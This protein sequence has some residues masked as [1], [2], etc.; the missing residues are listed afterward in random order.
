MELTSAIV[1]EPSCKVLGNE[2]YS[3]RKISCVVVRKGGRYLVC[4]QRDSKVGSN[5]E[6]VPVFIF[7]SRRSSLRA[8]MTI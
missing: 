6:D 7:Y 5:D 8:A 4:D 3:Y 2:N 1:R